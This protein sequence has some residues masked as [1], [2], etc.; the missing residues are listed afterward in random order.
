M[1]FLVCSVFSH[2]MKETIQIFMLFCRIALLCHLHYN[3]LNKIYFL[4]IWE[5][6]KCQNISYGNWR[7]SSFRSE[8]FKIKNGNND[9]QIA[10]YPWY[11]DH[12]VWGFHLF[13]MERICGKSCEGWHSS[14]GTS[15]WIHFFTKSYRSSNRW[16]FWLN[17]ILLINKDNMG[18][19]ASILLILCSSFY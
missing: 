2:N 9:K 18:D 10:F 8:I 14:A 4:G 15:S 6:W 1:Y 19:H 17:L 3:F 13:H 5:Q 12:Q 16:V 7:R 11:Y